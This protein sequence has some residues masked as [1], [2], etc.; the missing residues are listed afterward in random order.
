MC[1]L[2]CRFRRPIGWVVGCLL[3]SGWVLPLPLQVFGKKVMLYPLKLQARLT[4]TYS[5]ISIA[6]A[7]MVTLPPAPLL[8]HQ[9]SP[10]VPKP[11][12]V[13]LLRISTLSYC[14]QHAIINVCTLLAPY[15]ILILSTW[16]SLLCSA[17]GTEKQLWPPTLKT[18]RLSKTHN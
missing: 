8:K 13:S 12:E 4:P 15:S 18:T 5:T 16:Y 1:R 14:N 10:K 7:I 3:G 2:L 9:S 6:S 17:P 11:M